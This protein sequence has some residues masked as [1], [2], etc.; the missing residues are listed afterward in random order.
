MKINIFSSIEK[1]GSRECDRN[2]TLGKYRILKKR[3]K[4]TARIAIAFRSTGEAR[5]P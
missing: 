1:E 5:W 4:L 3:D 2:V